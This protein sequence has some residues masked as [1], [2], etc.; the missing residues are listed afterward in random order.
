MDTSS[1][2]QATHSSVSVN[3]HGTSIIG[4]CEKDASVGVS[5]FLLDGTGI[6][7]D[8]RIVKR[9]SDS[10]TLVV[11]DASRRYQGNNRR[12]IDVD[13]WH[14][15]K[16]FI[17]ALNVRV[18]EQSESVRS[19]DCRSTWRHDRTTIESDVVTPQGQSDGGSRCGSG[20]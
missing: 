2:D 20:G 11:H 9:S 8:S 6:K 10:C 5:R 13:G 3:G 17:G 18:G 4:S 16:Y 12:I 7:H 15:I 1:G 14:I 19:G